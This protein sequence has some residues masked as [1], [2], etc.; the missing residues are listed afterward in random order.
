[1]RRPGTTHEMPM[2]TDFLLDSLVRVGLLPGVRRL[3]DAPSDR[4]E[5]QHSFH[6]PNTPLTKYTKS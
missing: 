1:M 3:P 6:Y 2:P 4:C 5:V